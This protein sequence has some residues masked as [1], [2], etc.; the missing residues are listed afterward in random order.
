M[1]NG[2]T[3]SVVKEL[4]LSIGRSSVAIGGRRYS[5]LRT[6]INKGIRHFTAEAFATGERIDFSV[7]GKN[8]LIY[9][10]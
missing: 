4:P 6:Y 9:A 7:K 3:F 10:H 8:A 1:G 5:L 2:V